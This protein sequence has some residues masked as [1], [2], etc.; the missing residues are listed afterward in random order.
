M[1]NYEKHDESLKRY[2]DYHLDIANKL[3][4]CTISEAAEKLYAELRSDRKVAEKLGYGRSTV[5]KHLIRMDVL[6]VKPG[7][8]NFKGKL[9]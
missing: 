5:R 4:F 6:R 8:A 7:G 2:Y 9:N 1:I 3:G